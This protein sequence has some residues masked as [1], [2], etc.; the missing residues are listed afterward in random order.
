MTRTE[1]LNKIVNDK[2]KAQLSKRLNELYNVALTSSKCSYDTVTR[3]YKQKSNDSKKE[4]AEK[5][6]SITIYLHDRNLI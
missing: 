4:I 3:C 5:I 1:W 6:L 2:T